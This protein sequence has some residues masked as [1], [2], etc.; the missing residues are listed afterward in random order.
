MF[1]YYLLK[2]VHCSQTFNPALLGNYTRPGVSKPLTGGSTT[3]IGHLWNAEKLLKVVFNY[4][5]TIICVRQTRLNKLATYS[6]AVC[7]FLQQPFT[8]S[9]SIQPQGG[10]AHQDYIDHPQL[11]WLLIAIQRSISIQEAVWKRECVCVR[12]LKR[13]LRSHPAFISRTRRMLISD[14]WRTSQQQQ[15]QVRLVAHSCV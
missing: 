2:C 11:T 1:T 9:P 4:L 12:A 3:T 7:P 5:P 14:T 10:A 6:A 8:F 15:Q 13:V